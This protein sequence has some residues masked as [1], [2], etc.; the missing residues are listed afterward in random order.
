MTFTIEWGWWLLP[1]AV[2]VAGA[3]V[4]LWMNR[5]ARGTAGDYSN[6]VAP[7]FD[8]L[9]WLLFFV[10]PSLAAWLVWALLR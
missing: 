6:A 5:Q 9:V 4:S 2:S 8:A 10:L 1:F 7:L 3:I